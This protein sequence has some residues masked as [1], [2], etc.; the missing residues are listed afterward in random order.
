MKLMLAVIFLCAALGLAARRFGVREHLSVVV[1]AGTMTLLYY[2]FA[3]R[4]M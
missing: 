4:L 3:D 1:V 2:V